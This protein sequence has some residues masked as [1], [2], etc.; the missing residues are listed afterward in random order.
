MSNV[1]RASSILAKIAAF[2]RSKH[3]SDAQKAMFVSQLKA[4]L[5]AIAGQGSLPLQDGVSAAPAAGKRPA[6]G[7]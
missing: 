1:D 7:S 5:D 2:E 4:E 6:Q 3:L